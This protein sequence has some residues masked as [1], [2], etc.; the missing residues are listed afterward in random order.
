[1]K[2]YTHKT[3]CRICEGTDLVKILDL[4]STPLANAYLKREDLGKPEELF[5]L[6][7]YFCRTCS[8]AQLLD[9]VDPELLFK[10]YHFLTTASSPSVAHFEKYAQEVILPLITSPEDL[11]IDIGGNDGVLLSF[12]KDHA[13]VLNV[14]PAENLAPISEDKGVPFY[15]AF[16]PRRRQM[17][18]LQSTE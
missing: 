17:T 4:G 9:V 18:S 2:N 5:P 7:L 16:L 3:T 6:V 15:P 12:V 10:D 13:H 8:L 14:D 11:V 1:M